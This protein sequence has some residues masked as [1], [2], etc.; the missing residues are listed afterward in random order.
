MTD[1]SRIRRLLEEANPVP[2]PMAAHSD[3]SAADV[4]FSAI[5]ERTGVMHT[6]PATKPAEAVQPPKRPWYRRPVT[7][8]AAAVVVTILA[9]IP[10][11]LFG[12]TGGDVV[13]EP[14]VTSIPTT[15]TSVPVPTTVT[16]LGDADLRWVETRLSGSDAR[17]FDANGYGY[18]VAVDGDRIVIGSP[19]K[20][21]GSRYGG[22][23]YVYESDGNG[24]WV[25]TKLTASDGGNGG[26]FGMSVAVDGDIVV[27][28]RP[29]ELGSEGPS[30]THGSR[31][32]AYVYETDGNGGWVE[33][34]LT[35]SDG[36][37]LDEFGSS[38]A[39]SGGR[40]VV[41]AGGDDEYSGSVYVFERDGQGGWLE[42]KLTASDRAPR[43]NFGYRAS[44]GLGVPV[45]VEGDRIAVGSRSAVYLFESDSNGRWVETRL[46]VPAYR[47]VID[48]D[49]IVIGST[50]AV[51]IYERDG[52]G[53]WN[54]TDLSAPVI[55]RW[56]D[57]SDDRIAATMDATND[58]PGL[59][60]V[61]E[62]GGEGDW[63]ETVLL[64][65]DSSPM[66][67]GRW[68][69]HDWVVATDG[70]RVVVGAPNAFTTGVA[71]VYEWTSD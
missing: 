68:S 66:D 1:P 39:V 47:V 41:G 6:A 50:S 55:G 61:L 53:D 31:G 60:Y 26:Q 43:A 17:A 24:G 29:F 62:I 49:R 58:S 8:F 34:K 48:G 33:T 13:V 4:L 32:A 9:A 27:V 59:A 69:H 30:E 56:L 67:D 46:A 35:A 40:I 7:I 65:S 70:D 19:I 2:D 14:P 38:V 36:A 71:F 28:G 21:E 45:A 51:Y 57:A 63:V 12:S 3:E 11:F 23:A 10:L 22:A 5:N 15:V 42:T 37:D 54:E 44:L 16:S 52:T 18:D 64:S 20:Y 25:E